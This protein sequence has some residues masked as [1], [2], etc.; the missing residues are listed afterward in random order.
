MQ[1]NPTGAVAL[2]TVLGLSTAGG[3]VWLTTDN[4]LPL[5]YLVGIVGVMFGIALC[6][7]RIYDLWH[8]RRK[9]NKR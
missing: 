9:R 4:L 5:Y 2:D 1:H 6:S 7:Y 8:D 3:G